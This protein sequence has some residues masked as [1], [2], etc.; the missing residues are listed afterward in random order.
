MA[1][2]YIALRQWADKVKDKLV[3]KLLKGEYP[4]HYKEFGYIPEILFQHNAVQAKFDEMKKDES[5]NASNKQRIPEKDPYFRPGLL[6]VYLQSLVSDMDK[7]SY[8]IYA[9]RDQ[10][11]A[12]FFQS[13]PQLQNVSL[14]FKIHLMFNVKY[15][16]SVLPILFNELIKLR[17]LPIYFKLL[18]YNPI[19]SVPNQAGIP[20]PGFD[21]VPTPDYTYG[22]NDAEKAK[23]GR[24]AEAFIYS[25]TE[26]KKYQPTV[27]GFSTFRLDGKTRKGKVIN[28]SYNIESLFDPVLVFYTS[29]QEYTKALLQELLRIFPDER[30]KEWVLPNFYPRANVKINN[31][32]YVANGDF[33][34]KYNKQMKCKFNIDP[35]HPVC[36]LNPNY[37]LLDLPEEYQTIQNSCESRE[38]KEQCDAA[39]R[40]PLAVS[41]NKL[42]KWESDKCKPEKTYSQHLLLQDYD[43]LEQ[44]YDAVGQRAVLDGFK[45]GNAN[46]SLPANYNGGRR[47]KRTRRNKQS[48]RKNKNKS[49]RAH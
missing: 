33:G 13:N 29:D 44:L 4:H 24:L 46:A 12:V 10:P 17:K 40:F 42:C 32:I 3:P 47:S 35:G 37:S 20:T 9:V 28:E 18:S 14:S 21:G 2:E 25:P 38:A 39:N 15:I 6:K 26:I 30:T 34:T 41:N 49:R 19:T 22:V 7:R 16:S 45:A 23:Y 31:M 1:E 27:R 36:Y 8:D 43:S 48:K 5:I 11:K